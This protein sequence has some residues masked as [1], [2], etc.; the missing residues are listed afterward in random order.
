MEQDA[1]KTASAEHNRSM[2]VLKTEADIPAT[3]TYIT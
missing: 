1:N 3:H 2:I